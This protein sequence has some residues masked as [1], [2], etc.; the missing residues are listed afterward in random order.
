MIVSPDLQNM[1]LGNTIFFMYDYLPLKGYF[2]FIA[3]SES[4]YFKLDYKNAA[5][6]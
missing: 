4:Q 3:G 6:T 1:A 5:H 2:K